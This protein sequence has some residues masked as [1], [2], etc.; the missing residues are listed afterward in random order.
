MAAMSGSATQRREPVWPCSNASFAHLSNSGRCRA[1]IRFA[2]A[3]PPFT[4][5]KTRPAMD[6]DRHHLSCDQFDQAS[7]E[8][9][10][11]RRDRVRRERSAHRFRKRKAV[12]E[13]L[14][15]F[16]FQHWA[17]SL[18]GA[19]PSREGEGKGADR[20]VDGL[21]YFYETERKDIPG[22]V[23]DEPLPRSEPS[24]AKKSLCRSKA[25]EE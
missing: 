18:I 22:R 2:D 6:R 3:A 9:C 21:L 13:A 25:A 8:G 15:K 19:R 1:S 4:P 5:R 17:L 10:V 11:R 16:Q 23:R 12:A 14:D 7:I 20:S 24:I